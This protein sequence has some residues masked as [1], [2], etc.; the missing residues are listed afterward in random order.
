MGN[1]KMLSLFAATMITIASFADVSS[2]DI[3]GTYIKNA[4]FEQ[5]NTGTAPWSP[6]YWNLTFPEGTGYGG[7]QSDQLSVNTKEGTYDWH[8]WYGENY[9]SNRL[10]Q[11]ISDLP[12]GDYLLTGY[13]R[14]V[15][16]LAVTGQQRLFATVGDGVINESTVYSAAYNADGHI[17]IN[18]NDNENIN[19]WEK[20]S[21]DFTVAETDN[22]TI[23][24]DCPY[25][26]SRT[27]QGF[28]VDDVRL[29]V[30][31]SAVMAVNSTVKYGTFCAPFEVVPP[32]GVTAYTCAETEESTLTLDAVN[33]IPANTPVI[34]Y[35][36]DGCASIEFKG[37][38]EGTSEIVNVGLLY[39]NV[40]DAAQ[41]ITDTGHEYILQR[42]DGVTAFYKIEGSG[43]KVGANRCYLRLPSEPS[44]R[45]AFYFDEDDDP[46]SV[47]SIPDSGINK[48]LGDG[49]YIINGRVVV[50][51]NGV[52]YSLNGQI[53]N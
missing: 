32:T 31:S 50:V 34:L 3:T 5:K 53:M 6:T 19:N 22:V 51:K 11:T 43:Y 29:Y 8:I 13:M 41:Y 35:A 26:S 18:N 42:Q 12:A 10:Y 1:K 16:N 24:F 15:D 52:K 30:K 40:T 48:T 36:E 28:Q 47:T 23:G 14:C 25:V 2:S 17:N 21:V 7:I 45:L 27:T 4:G 49:T 39:G 46:T 37:V 38:R 9:V 44:A 20:L 33:P